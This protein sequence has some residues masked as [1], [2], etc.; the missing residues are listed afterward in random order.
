M[1]ASFKTFF[2]NIAQLLDFVPLQLLI[3][4]CRQKVIVPV[5]H[6]VSDEKSIHIRHLYSVRTIRQFKKDLDFLLREYHPMDIKALLQYAVSG[7]QPE[8]QGFILTFDDGL[9]EIY[10]IV[11]PILIDRGVTA[12]F[13]VN[14]SFVDNKDLFYRYKASL[15]KE[16][17]LTRS[18]SPVQVKLIRDLVGQSGIPFD[19]EGRYILN[20][21]YKGK[22]V[23]DKIADVLNVDFNEFLLVQKPYMTSIQLEELSKLGFLIGAHSLDHPNYSEIAPADQL[24]QTRQS[25]SMVCREFTQQYRLFAFPFTDDGISVSFFDSVFDPV[26]PLADLTFGTAGVKKDIV[27]RNIQRIPFENGAYSAEEMIKGEYLYYILKAPFG[28]NL[29][30]R[31]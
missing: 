27:C 14:P 5:Y 18:L 29:I 16:A 17:M 31:N 26:N 3:S 6:T 23:L 12:I 10:D 9:R 4:L 28:K 24:N 21:K 13:F 2:I 7:R 15:L 22:A 25:I 30:R 19:R 1:P 8:R 20:I 11:A